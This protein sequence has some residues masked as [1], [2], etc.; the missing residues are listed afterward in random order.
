[1]STMDRIVIVGAGLAGARAAEAMRTAGY[2]GGL[3]LLGEEAHRPYLR[4]P[5][6]K[7][8][9]RGEKPIE[10]VYVHPEAF[11]DEHRIDLRVDTAVDA[12]DP[13]AHEV[14][15]AD[16]GRVPYD[17][18]LLAT[19]ARPRPLTV[20]GAELPGVVALRTLDDADA[21]AR[22]A[23]DAERVVV[24]GAGWIGSEVAASLRTLGRTVAVVA[25][26][27]L[28]LERVLG[29]EIGGVYRDLHAEHGVELHLGSSVA[30]LVGTDQ[31]TAVETETG[32]R[33]PADLVVVGIGAV[34][35][36][37]L[38]AAAGLRIEGGI[39]VDEHFRTSMPDIFA[40]G[41]VAAGWHPF[42][43]RR[44][45]TE[46]WAN[47]KFG[48]TAAGR[49]VVGG[50]EPFDRI[51]YFYSDQYDLG[52]EYTGLAGPGDRLVVRGGLDDRSFIAFWVDDAGRVTAGM[53]ANIWE[54]A[55]P[56]ERLIRS[57]ATVDIDALR[58]DAVAIDDLARV[59]TP[60]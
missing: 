33:L 54:V 48:G 50:G 46:H 20:P 47:A 51:P 30:R 5:L 6:S 36:T 35:R 49:A 11:Y 14:V 32:E 10:K 26:D 37:E 57:R 31:V 8:Y 3:T 18:L 39:E 9:L 24:I 15:L 41:D 17:R 27:A 60:A 2:E 16:G 12:I 7:E 29:P 55:K 23:R 52:M 38:A 28:P 22:A 19:G 34:P 59:A 21:L 56:I 44:I 58:D 25:P 45:R 1:M 42:L 53:N 43:G 40:V 13:G 4:P